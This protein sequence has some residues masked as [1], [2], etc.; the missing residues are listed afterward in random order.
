MKSNSGFTSGEWTNGDQIWTGR[1]RV[2]EKGSHTCRILL[3]DAESGELFAECPFV[4]GKRSATVFDAS[5]SSRYF[6]LRIQGEGGRH[7]FVGLGFTERNHSF[8]FNV[9]LGEHEKHARRAEREKEEASAAAAAA[10]LAPKVDRSLKAGETI[11]IAIK[12]PA[13]GQGERKSA[14]WMS[15]AK[16]GLAGGL[17]LAP[18]GAAAGGIRPHAASKPAATASSDPF[19]ALSAPS[20]PAAAASSDSFAALSAPSAPAAAASS[21]PFAA[22]SAPSAPAAAVVDPFAVL[23]T[24]TA[25][26]PAKAAAAAIDPFAALSAPSTP[27]TATPAAAVVDPFADLSLGAGGSGSG[28][29]ASVATPSGW[30]QF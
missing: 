15:S 1:L 25:P 3:E 14:G 27:A 22:L 18:P 20:A 26:A 21:D 6:V 24:P 30:A 11:T 29:A 7:A 13:G 10:A 19:A 16:V 17:K 9:A 12:K 28:S 5:D 4:A 2:V 23:S 8:D